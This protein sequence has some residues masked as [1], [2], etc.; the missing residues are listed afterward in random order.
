LNYTI[1]GKGRA[2]I[3]LHGFMESSVMWKYYFSTLSQYFRVIAIDLPGHGGSDN[4]GYVHTMELMAEAVKAVVDHYRLRRI[5]IAGHSLGG[6]VALA[7]AEAYVDTVKSISLINSTAY[8]DSRERKEVRNKAI[9]LLKNGGKKKFIKQ[10][11]PSLFYRE[12]RSY[13]NIIRKYINIANSTSLQGIIAGLE[14]MKIRKDRSVIV[15]FAPFPILFIGGEYDHLIA[16]DDVK[17]QV[18]LNE[19]HELIIHEDVG[20]MSMEESR[21][22]TWTSI[23]NFIKANTT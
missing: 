18:H 19:N 15:Q 16:P 10:V 6:Y 5:H 23:K 1:A 20:H 12:H 17:A 14:G 2:L 9:E 7:Y 4:F 8:A 3:L 11:V 22:Q 21:D 13:H